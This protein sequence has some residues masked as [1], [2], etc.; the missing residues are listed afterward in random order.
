MERRRCTWRHKKVHVEGLKT[1]VRLS[2][3]CVRVRACPLSA[4]EGYHDRWS[5]RRAKA[6][7]R[8]AAA[9]RVG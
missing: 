4:C 5:R 1:L 6:R 2:E 8:L 7:P 3:V 9:E